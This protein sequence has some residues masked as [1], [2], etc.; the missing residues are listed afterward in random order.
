MKKL[1]C[2]IMVSL[3]AAPA[4]LAQDR[5][6]ADKL[7]TYMHSGPSSQYRIIGSI[8]AGDKVRLLSTNRENG[9]SQVQDSRG[10][11]GWVET[12]Y[13]TTQESMAVRLP[14]L[15]KELTEAKSLLANAR[16]TANSEKDGLVSSLEAR[17]KQIAELEQ[18]YSDISSQ[19][20]SSQTE[21][22]ELRAKLDTQ[23]EDLLLRYFMYGGGVAGAGLLFGLILPHIIP[24]R[25]KS[26]NGWA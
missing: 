11:K 7:F 9:Y 4:A 25:K 2:M 19:L 17:N 5:Y 8:N 12:K 20:T 18:N 22:R 6:I 24:R 23:K 3:L 10:R 1:I 21:I 26:P 13:V 15:E 16:Q 14:R